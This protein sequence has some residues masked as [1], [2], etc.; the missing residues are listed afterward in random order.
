M[1]NSAQ[2]DPG[3]ERL[4]DIMAKLRHPEDGCPWD[5]E[6]TFATIAPYTIEE[7]YE[8]AEAIGEDDHAALCEEL[9]DLLFQ[10]IFHARMAEEAGAFAFADVVAAVCDKMVRRHPHIF[11]DAQVADAGAQT[12]AWEAAKAA[13]RATKA[14]RAGRVASILD[15]VP[16]GFP[17][18]L[19]ALK[20]QKRASRVGFDWQTALPALAKIEEEIGELRSEIAAGGS[21]ERLADEIGD[22]LFSFVNVA[23]HLAIDPES[24]L[25]GTN[26]KF[27]RRFR[28][29]EAKLAASEES[30]AEMSLDDLDRLWEEAKSEIESDLGELPPTPPL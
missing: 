22:G 28:H 2:T 25:R 14:E 30:L 11:A 17:A 23:R 20:L 19:R 12:V 6:Q 29:I 4:L 9:G 24:A 3:I 27:E 1:K 18:L 8:V 13:E 7:A 21:P 5:S 26:A 16:H 15:D 10:V